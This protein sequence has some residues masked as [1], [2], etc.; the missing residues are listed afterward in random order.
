L[1]LGYSYL[2]KINIIND[3][4]TT[5]N[6]LHTIRDRRP[7]TTGCPACWVM[8]INELRKKIFCTGPTRASK[9]GH[10]SHVP[11]R[12][13]QPRKDPFHL[14]SLSPHSPQFQQSLVSLVRK[15]ACMKEK[16]E[17]NAHVGKFVKTQGILRSSML[18]YSRLASTSSRV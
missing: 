13:A 15:C 17:K 3:L 2:P 11:A 9:A 6:E 16:I 8:G 4:T 12:Q 10:K 14:N 18:C 5:V 1:F 7:S